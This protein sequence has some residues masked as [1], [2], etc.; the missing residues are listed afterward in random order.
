MHDYEELARSYKWGG[1]DYNDLTYEQQQYA[2]LI[3]KYMMNVWRRILVTKPYKPS[4]KF[5]EPSELIADFSKV[6]PVPNN[7]RE[8]HEQFIARLVHIQLEKDKRID[9]TSMYPRIRKVK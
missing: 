9:V 2:C 7:Y 6:E 3:S 4:I 8:E 1:Q 5:I